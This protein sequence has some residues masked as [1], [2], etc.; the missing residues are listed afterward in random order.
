MRP[1]LGIT[2][3]ETGTGPVFKSEA[4]FDWLRSYNPGERE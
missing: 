4:L 1:N 3:E 2:E